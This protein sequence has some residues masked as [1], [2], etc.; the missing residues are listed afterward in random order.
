M[1]DSSKIVRGTIE[2]HPRGF[3]FLNVEPTGD[4]RLSAFVPPPEL[5]RFLS[6]DRVQ[7][8][9]AQGGDGRWSASG[10][11][12]TERRRQQVFGELVMRRGHP[13]LRIDREIANTDWPIELGK[14]HVAPDEAVVARVDGERLV[15]ERKVDPRDTSLERVLVRHGIRRHRPEG[16]EIAARAL[17]S[18]PH[19]VGARRDLREV[20]TIT[21]DAASTRDIDDAISVLPADAD[22]ALRLMVSIADVSEFVL[23][24][25]PLDASARERAAAPH[26]HRRHPALRAN[27]RHR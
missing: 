22:G 16:E 21:L 26:L 4:E 14:T 1:P 5:N 17:L 23:E 19:A 25:S 8:T 11:Q 13:H 9:I 20:P 24:G 12:L 3:G 18:R 6:G 15:F 27:R 2:V 10:L 7:A